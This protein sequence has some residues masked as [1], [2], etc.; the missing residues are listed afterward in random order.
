MKSE[1]ERGGQRKHQKKSIIHSYVSP[2]LSSSAC[3]CQVNAGSC[4]YRFQEVIYGSGEAVQPE[5]YVGLG[6]VTEFRFGVALYNNFH[7]GAQNTMQY[8]V[9]FG[10]DWGFLSS[11]SAVTFT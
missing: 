11:D 5:Q 10:E 4:L 3:S 7:E 2:S 6:Q 8:L 1:S 9:D